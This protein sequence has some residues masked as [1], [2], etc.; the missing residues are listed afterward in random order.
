ML[1]LR[2]H[3]GP[4]LAASLSVWSS[5]WT[6]PTTWQATQTTWDT[7]PRGRARCPGSPLCSPPWSRL[8]ATSTSCSTPAR[9]WSQSVT[10]SPYRG[11]RPAGQQPVSLL[12]REPTSWSRPQSFVSLCS[13]GRCVVMRRGSVSRCSA[14]WDCSGPRTQTAVSFQRREGTRPACCRRTEST[15][16]TECLPHG[17]EASCWRNDLLSDSHFEPC[18]CCCCFRGDRV[19]AQPLQVSVRSLRPGHQT[20]WRTPGLWWPQWWGQLWWDFSK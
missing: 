6:C 1:I 11:S 3:F 19:L 18:C 8:A 9:C 16:R 7:C 10:R 5:A 15:V 14:L 13:A 2:L 12:V 17:A 20:L 4:Q